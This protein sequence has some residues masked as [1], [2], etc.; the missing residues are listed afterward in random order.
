M[1]SW[2]LGIAATHERVAPHG[3]LEAAL[4]TVWFNRSFETTVHAIALLRSNP[5]REPVRIVGSHVD[6]AS[7]VL[8][9]CDIVEQ[10][11]HLA[12]A[13]Y[14][15]WALELCRRH[16][17]D[18]LIPRAHAATLAAAR[19]SFA[20]HGV[21]VAAGPSERIALL[22][23]KAAAYADAERAGLRVPPYRVARSAR[24]LRSAYEALLPEGALCIK[25]LSAAGGDGFRM[26]TTRRPDLSMIQ[27]PYEPSLHLDDAAAALDAA[28]PSALL[29]MPMLPGPEVSVD[30]LAE[31]DGTLLVTVARAKLHRRVRIGP[32]P[33]ATAMAAAIVD[34]NRLGYL[35]NTQV[36]YWQRPGHDDRPRAYLLETNPRMSA[37]LYQTA[38]AGVNLPWAAVAIAVGRSPGLTEPRAG[39]E[40]AVIP[41]ALPVAVP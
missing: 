4:L 20:A 38:L 28:G 36:R 6:P 17:V 3:S 41:A 16:D 21:A 14:V 10:E 9:A 15:H 33:E 1:S 2:H 8:T 40:L 22:E 29:V 5:E 30:C 26:L 39:A 18:V 19:S 7:P 23:D 13:D 24:E 27:G 32:D 34:R 37:G 25:P 11:P 31:S 35:S 12:P